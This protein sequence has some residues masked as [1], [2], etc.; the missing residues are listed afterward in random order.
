MGLGGPP[1]VVKAS[2]HI[3]ARLELSRMLYW[4]VVWLEL[5]GGLVRRGFSGA[6]A[7]GRMGIIWVVG[8]FAFPALRIV[9]LETGRR[10]A[11]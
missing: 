4:M 6:A 8:G 3:I 7:G 1:G 11:I 5:W 9:Q 10:N 2:A